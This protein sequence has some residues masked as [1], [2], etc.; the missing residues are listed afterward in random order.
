MIQAIQYILIAQDLLRLAKLQARELAITTVEL[1]LVTLEACLVLPVASTTLESELEARLLLATTLNDYTTDLRRAEDVLAKGLVRIGSRETYIP[2][3]LVFNELLARILQELG[4]V[5][6]AKSVI[7]DSIVICNE[8]G[9]PLDKWKL[10]FLLR[11]FEIEYSHSSVRNIRV[12]AI[13]RGS[14]D[15]V[16]L[17][18][19]LDSIV[20]IRQGQPLPDSTAP[21]NYLQG[22]SPQ[23]T[24]LDYMLLAVAII[25]DV[26]AGKISTTDP[27]VD[28]WKCAQSKLAI[29]HAGLDAN[30]QIDT[31]LAIKIKTNPT[32]DDSS[33][34]LC[35]QTFTTQRL[36]IFI[37][38]LS[39]VVHLADITSTKAEKFLAEGQKQLI[40]ERHASPLPDEW[41]SSTQVNLHLCKALNF[42][43]HMKLALA[44]A[45]IASLLQ[46]RFE[47]PFVYFLQG[48]IAQLKGE[49]DA[50]LAHYEKV[51]HSE[52]SIISLLNTVLILRGNIRSNAARAKDLLQYLEPV[53]TT[54]PLL[55]AFQIVS[56][57]SHGT[58]SVM[59]KRILTAVLNAAKGQVNTQFNLL[60]L[61]ILAVKSPDPDEMRLKF[62]SFALNQAIKSAS[63]GDSVNVWALFNGQVVEQMYDKARDS[64]RAAKAKELSHKNREALKSLP[65]VHRAFY[66]ST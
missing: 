21:P 41:L 28:N 65:A 5:N 26:L 32:N 16:Q 44:E 50:A 38:L 34:Q 33:E 45:E 11:S 13:S 30:P 7:K 20:Y 46:M 27:S 9:Q 52:I 15:L 66:P 25:G 1:V 57:T 43:L 55:T 56:S 4:S 63:G 48:C 49:M 29:I 42:L 59:S 47:S 6:A 39:G 3:K 22:Q 18:N 2:Y 53:C 37:Y 14:A 10:I 19:L 8:R 64:E 17:C 12:M 40:L 36:M 31:T 62:A 35:F 54:G 61:S 23:L 60:G 24:V 51:T 58:S